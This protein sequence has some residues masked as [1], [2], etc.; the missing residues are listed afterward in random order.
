MSYDYFA[1]RRACSIKCMFF[2]CGDIGLMLNFDSEP[3]CL[4]DLLR[5]LLVTQRLI[6]ESRKHCLQKVWTV[7]KA[8]LLHLH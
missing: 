1:L 4:W 3:Q 7:R 8:I 2:T 6:E 5:T